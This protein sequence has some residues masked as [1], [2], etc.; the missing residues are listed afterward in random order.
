MSVEIELEKLL[1]NNGY[2]SKKTKG[3]SIWTL[4]TGQR[5]SEVNYHDNDTVAFNYLSKHMRDMMKE[6]NNN[7]I[8]L[9][10][11]EQMTLFHNV[12]SSFPFYNK[13]KNHIPRPKWSS[14]Q[15][16]EYFSISSKVGMD[17]FRE[18]ASFIVSDGDDNFKQSPIGNNPK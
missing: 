14:A 12:L 4:Y 6:H 7:I 3:G 11:D 16:I 2:I 9:K 5:G 10:F 18:I 8:G 1:K 17:V 15:G 13:I